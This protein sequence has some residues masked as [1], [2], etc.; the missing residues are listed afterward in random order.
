MSVLTTTL[1]IIF[2]LGYSFLHSDYSNARLIAITE[3][4]FSPLQQCNGTK[5]FLQFYAPLLG[6]EISKRLTTKDSFDT[7]IAK[8]SNDDWISTPIVGKFDPKFTSNIVP[9][10]EYSK[11]FLGRF[12]LKKDQLYLLNRDEENSFLFETS[13]LILCDVGSG[14]GFTP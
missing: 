14:K 6:V 5:G 11:L 3:V 13:S 2:A 12:V 1:V 9:K 7:I 8:L 10:R 4:N